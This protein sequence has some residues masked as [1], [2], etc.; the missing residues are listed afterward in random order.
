MLRLYLH[1]EWGQCR[2][3]M[4]KKRVDQKGKSSSV[5]RILF[6]NEHINYQPY[7]AQRMETET[8]RNEVLNYLFPQK[9]RQPWE[10]KCSG[11]KIVVQKLT[12]AAAFSW[13]DK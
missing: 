1:V 10:K 11:C 4:G 3:W 8:K 9:I 7:Q 12:L 13:W 5:I 6:G 2:K